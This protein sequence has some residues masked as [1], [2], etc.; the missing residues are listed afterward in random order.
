MNTNDSKTFDEKAR[1]F[2]HHCISFDV[3]TEDHMKML[4]S[5]M[6][7]IS[8]DVAQI[9]AHAKAQVKSMLSLYTC[10]HLVSYLPG[11]NLR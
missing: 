10:T 2:I 6:D 9:S 3:C 1:L 8:L 7:S 11:S 4:Q 5:Q